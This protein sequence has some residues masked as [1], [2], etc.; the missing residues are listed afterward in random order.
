MMFLIECAS[1]M[2]AMMRNCALHLGH[3]SRLS[4]SRGSNLEL[5][6]LFDRAPG[7]P[8]DAVGDPYRGA[9]R[10]WSGHA[11]YLQRERPLFASL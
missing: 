7:A 9:H 11:D 4:P 3:P 1:W 8:V 5:L 2:K 10:A 6:L